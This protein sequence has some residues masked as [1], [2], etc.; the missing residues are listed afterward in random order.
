MKLGR[1]VAR[2]VISQLESDGVPLPGA[3]NPMMTVPSK[4]EVRTEAYEN[5]RE[6]LKDPSPKGQRRCKPPQQDPGCEAD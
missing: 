3:L 2:L 5:R 1:C 4:A 6:C